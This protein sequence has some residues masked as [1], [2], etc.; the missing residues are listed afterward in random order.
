MTSVIIPAD[1]EGKRDDLLE[2]VIGHVQQV[3]PDAEIIICRGPLDPYNKSLVCNEGV[4][5][6]T[7]DVLLFLDSDMLHWP[8][9]LQRAESVRSWGVPSG[10]VRNLM[11]DNG[12]GGR[13]TTR[14][15]Q[16]KGRGGLFA[17]TR[18]AFESVGGFDEEFVGWGCED[19]AL[20]ITAC[21][22]LGDPED[23]GDEPSWHLYH[24]PQPERAKVRRSANSPNRARLTRLLSGGCMRIKVTNG[25]QATIARAGLVFRPG[26]TEI[27][28]PDDY[29]LREIRACRFLA[30][31]V[32]EDKRP[33]PV[34]ETPADR[35]P[36]DPPRFICGCGKVCKNAAGLSAHKRTCKV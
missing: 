31:T 6:A 34:Q 14:P 19:E 16:I 26:V 17:F 36:Q 1:D 9:V 35:T 7:G 8:S 2:A 10:E 20:Y 29:K 28:V 30:V 22:R 15:G 4:A 23:L 5:R 18:K 25:Q 3:L 11:K 27:D 24:P 12:P 21:A 33:A 13:Y 32:I